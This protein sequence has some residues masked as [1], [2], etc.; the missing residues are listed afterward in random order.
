MAED[1]LQIETLGEV[2]RITLNRPDRLNAVDQPMAD[3][4]LAAFEGLRRDTGA[5]VVILRGAGRAFSAGADLKSAGT[6]TAL[7]DGPN[8]DWVLR[9]VGK[10]MR[11]CPQPIIALVKGAAAGGGLA[12]A[13]ASDIVVA[14]E[15]AVFHSAFIKI[16]LSGAELGVGWRLQRT[17]GISRAREAL[18]TG[19]PIDAAEAWRTGLVSTVVP[20]AAL[21][22]HGAALAEKMLKAAPDALR[23]T[24]RTLDAA[25]ETGVEAAMEIEERGQMLTIRQMRGR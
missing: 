11:A 14:G 23:I 2:R 13:L 12:L 22:D 16:G 5:R 17:M 21:D 6:P 9:D 15:S 18:F 1:I 3:A 4:L 20:D 7:R 19:D 8:G 25:L 10:A 24:K